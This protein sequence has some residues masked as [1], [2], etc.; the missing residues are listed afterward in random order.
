MPLRRSKVEYIE[1]QIIRLLSFPLQ[2]FMPYPETPKP[3]LDLKIISRHVCILSL[4]GGRSQTT[5]TR[6][7]G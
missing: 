6:R 3:L 5:L 7:G 2:H 4:L 1:K